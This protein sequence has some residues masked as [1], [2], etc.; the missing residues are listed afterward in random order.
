MLELMTVNGIVLDKTET[1]K[2]ETEFQISK[3]RYIFYPKPEF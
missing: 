2:H 3:N 1:D